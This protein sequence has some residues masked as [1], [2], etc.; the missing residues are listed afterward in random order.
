M[1]LFS[2]CVQRLRHDFCQASHSSY[3]SANT[4]RHTSIPR[5]QI[6]FWDCSLTGAQVA[7][8]LR[9]LDHTQLDINTLQDTSERIISSS[10]QPLHTQRNRHKRRISIISERFEPAI[11]ATKRLDIYVLDNTATQIEDSNFYFVLFYFILPY[12]ILSYFILFYFILFYFILF[13]FIVFYF[14]LFC[15]I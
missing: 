2:H 1:Q 7:P 6:L 14:I 13:Y 15:L 10:Q 9:F 8:L 4:I 12:F 11:P 3:N 5:A